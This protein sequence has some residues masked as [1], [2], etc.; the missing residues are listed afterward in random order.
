MLS[1]ENLNVLD[2]RK[3]KNNNTHVIMTDLYFSGILFSTFFAALNRKLDLRI[4]DF[5]IGLLFPLV[6]ILGVCILFQRIRQ[7][8]A[9][10]LTIGTLVFGLLTNLLIAMSLG[11]IRT[12]TFFRD[13][14]WNVDSRLFL[15]QTYSYLTFGNSNNSNSYSGFDIHYHASPSY[16]SA[17]VFDLFKI[18][19]N[20]T[21]FIAVPSVA[22]IALYL[23]SESIL[24]VSGLSRTCANLGALLVLSAS[25]VTTFSQRS[26]LLAPLINSELMLNAQLA[27]SVVLATLYFQVRDLPGKYLFLFSSLVSLVGLKPQYIPFAV[28]SY[29]LVTFFR[30]ELLSMKT[31]SKEFS[32][33]LISSILAVPFVLLL[34]NSEFGPEYTARLIPIDWA[35]FFRTNILIIIVAL[36][37]PLI[38]KLP[39]KER[40]GWNLRVLF[41]ITAIYL[42]CSLALELILFEPSQQI[43]NK[44]QIFKPTKSV[45]DSDF[46]QGLLLV[47]I[48]IL[49]SSIS[50]IWK[51]IGES[52]IKTIC[53][54]LILLSTLRIFCAVP[55]FV[56]PTKEGYEAVNLSQLRQTLAQAENRVSNPK[57]LVN[58]FVDPAENYRRDGSGMYWSSIG[59]GHFYLSDIK[60]FHFLAPD[61][62]LRLEK[63]KVFFN[64]PVSSFHIDFLQ[65]NDIDFVVVNLR[66]TPNWLSKIRPVYLNGS[67]ALLETK[68][69]NTRTSEASGLK[70]T[71]TQTQNFGLSRCL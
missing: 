62:R 6:C 56:H 18:N 60:T 27:V 14:T 58:D 12:L 61:I 9:S 47:F 55:E 37:L 46:N 38:A 44:M 29:M 49:I 5:F 71:L 30:A 8:K 68:S 52:S 69:F 40:F 4:L 70:S 3:R 48:L 16:I 63:T 10:K 65:E 7:E 26:K 13:L 15:S 31:A 66:C 45:G 64:S 36:I 54:T 34:S 50:L 35:N 24:R 21:L 19:P 23:S 22:L 17:Q 57:L 41:L 11:L 1:K 51:T 20:I 25:F 43:L 59:I 33:I 28:L 67:Y 32:K 42:A 53:V 39:N 2:V